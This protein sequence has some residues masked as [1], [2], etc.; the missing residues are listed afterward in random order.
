MAERILIEL[1]YLQLRKSKFKS[2]GI[3]KKNKSND[4][5]II[6]RKSSKLNKEALDV[7]SYQ[8]QL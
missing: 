5:N 3:R 6:N 2:K 4:L 8:V 7:L 1:Q